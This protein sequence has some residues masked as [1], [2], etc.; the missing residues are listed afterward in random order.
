MTARK[1][2]CSACDRCDVCY[3]H[4]MGKLLPRATCDRCG[5]QYIARNHTGH[6]NSAE[7][8]ST[9][10]EKQARADGYIFSYQNYNAGHLSRCDWAKPFLK[11]YETGV[12]SQGYKS[13][14]EKRWWAMK[15]WLPIVL[16]TKAMS[17]AERDKIMTQVRTWYEAGEMDQIDA[18]V[19]GLELAREAL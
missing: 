9:C 10:N 8:L 13:V 1:R 3:V 18:I 12:G 17:N 14:L 4:D 15:W 6:V 2:Y 11:Q 19:G 16:M 5:L 7:C